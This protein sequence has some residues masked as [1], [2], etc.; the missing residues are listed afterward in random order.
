MQQRHVHG[1]WTLL[2]ALARQK[3][4][5]LAHG[6]EKGATEPPRN[7]F[8]YTSVNVSRSLYLFC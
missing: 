8:L 6:K 7:G 3:F 2:P 1:P 4:V 5:F